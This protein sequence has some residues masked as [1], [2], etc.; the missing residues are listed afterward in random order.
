MRA[1]PVCLQL[2]GISHSFEKP[3]KELSELLTIEKLCE[4]T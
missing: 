2:H 4:T 3:S 1:V